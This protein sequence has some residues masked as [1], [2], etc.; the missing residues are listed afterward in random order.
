MNL[1]ENWSGGIPPDG[2]RMFTL[3]ATLTP[4]LQDRMHLANKSFFLHFL[5]E[6]S[7]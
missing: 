6:A 1:G 7:K 4:R 3:S 5:N 2:D